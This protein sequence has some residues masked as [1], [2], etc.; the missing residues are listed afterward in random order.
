M[1]EP[2]VAPPDDNQVDLLMGFL[3]DFR[4][5]G[6]EPEPEPEKVP[7]PQAVAGTS[8]LSRFDFAPPDPLDPHSDF[9]LPPAAPLPVWPPV[10]GSQAASAPVT[11]IDE[12]EP[13]P[14]APPEVSGEGNDGETGKRGINVFRRVGRR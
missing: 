10:P 9:D 14:Q 1:P 5:A 3:A 2:P 12:P 6:R 8:P 4:A 11:A 7:T 13:S